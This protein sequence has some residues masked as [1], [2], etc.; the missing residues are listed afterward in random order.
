MHKDGTL[1]AVTRRYTLGG[2]EPAAIE[3]L[4]STAFDLFNTLEHNLA[5][6]PETRYYDDTAVTL[7]LDRAAIPLFRRLLRQRGAAFLED[8]EGWITEHENPTALETVR[9]GVTVRM[10]VD[11]Q[12]EN[13]MTR[14]DSRR[15]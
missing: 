12:S 9:A 5:A 8:I 11:D 3:H 15:S 14:P 7:T 4:G 1:R 2:A 10:F 13:G 6:P